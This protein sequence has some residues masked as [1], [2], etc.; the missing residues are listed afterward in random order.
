MFAQTPKGVLQPKGLTEEKAG[1]MMAALREGKTLRTFG[2]TPDRLEAYFV[3]HPDYEREARP[4]IAANNVSALRN[5]GAHQ[6]AKTHCNYGHPLSGDN[7]LMFR[8]G[9]HRRC[10]LCMKTFGQEKRRFN[11]DQA[12]RVVAALQEGMTIAEVTAT[13]K[14]TYI[15][16]H[17]ALLL[18]RMKQPKFD[19]LVVRLSTHNAK[20]HRQESTIRRWAAYRSQQ[21]V[22]SPD[23]A[24]TAMRAA[25]P[26][27]L[28]RNDKEELFSR[29]ALAYAEGRDLREICRRTGE[30]LNAHFR[31]F[32]KFGPISLNAQL[33]SDGSATLLDRLSTENGTGWDLN[34]LASTGRRK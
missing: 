6:R 12:R 10:R 2:V 24:Y 32:S 1:R 33:F 4:L 8:G 23:E 16:N 20:L 28:P 34:M 22:I 21:R 31:M 29:M 11:E 5:K 18:F 9:K 26:P 15:V 13:G 19:Q 3:S 25:L 27:W 14:P 7:L 30:Y 17:R